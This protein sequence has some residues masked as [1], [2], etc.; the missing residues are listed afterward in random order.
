MKLAVA[1]QNQEYALAYLQ[2][3]VP[4]TLGLS[5]SPSS[6]PLARASGGTAR[7][8]LQ[9][10]HATRAQRSRS[11]SLPPR[12]RWASLPSLPS[13]LRRAA[14]TLPGDGSSL[15][16]SSSVPQELPTSSS[17]VLADTASLP[18][19]SLSAPDRSHHCQCP[20]RVT[21]VLRQCSRVATTAC[22]RE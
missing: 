6:Y 3:A 18:A 16:I 9:S 4:P 19:P 15:S 13:P 5:P 7:E 1:V 22:G 21:L 17:A 14:A 2:L 10:S 12:S 8:G 11:A 20:F